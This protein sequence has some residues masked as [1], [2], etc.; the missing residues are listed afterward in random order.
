MA[1]KQ[2]GEL[3][4]K[5]INSPKLD[6]KIKQSSSNQPSKY[7]WNSLYQF[8]DMTMY[9]KSQSQFPLIY[10]DLNVTQP[11]YNFG[12]GT[13]NTN[14]N[15]GTSGT[16]TNTGKY[17]ISTP[18]PKPALEINIGGRR[19]NQGWER[20]ITEAT[21]QGKARKA[22]KLKEKYLKW[23]ARQEKQAAKID[24]SKDF[25]AAKKKVKDYKKPLF[26]KRPDA[27]KDAVSQL[28]VD[29][30]SKWEKK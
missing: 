5:A 28:D 21:D 14:T 27:I 13:Q 9:G 12:A 19:T 6:G 2:K 1:I 25:D 11:N 16:G 20:R 29:G 30:I 26:G 17:D 23:D 4:W 3:T 22:A 24:S 18:P 8:G 10:Q 15:T 7:N